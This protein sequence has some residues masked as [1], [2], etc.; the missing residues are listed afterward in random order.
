MKIC[1]VA[2]GNIMVTPYIKKYSEICRNNNLDFDVI[3]WDRLGIKE[4][5]E[6]CSNIYSFNKSMPDDTPVCKKFVSMY[7]YAR[8]IKKI[9]QKNKYDKL[10][11]WTSL[12]GV[13]LESYITKKYKGK[14]IFDIRDYSYENIRWYY[15]KMDS[16]MKNSG[17][18]ILS[19]KG[20]MK[21]LPQNNY[22]VLHNCNYDSIGDYKFDNK[23]DKINIS[24]VGL[25][26]FEDKCKEFLRCIKNNEQIEFHFWGTGEGEAG[27]KEYCTDNH[28]DNVFFHG[29]YMPQEKGNICKNCD[30][31]FN[32]Y[33]NRLGLRYALSNKYYDALYYKKPLLVSENTIMEELSDGVS[34]TVEYNEKFAH[35]LLCKY[36]SINSDQ[37]NEHCESYLQSAID[38]N[39]RT[40]SEICKF[41]M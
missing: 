8:Y 20:F 36:K 13:F 30:M 15:N 37:F 35:E 40:E 17:L 3:Y 27:L 18:N 5:I 9:I 31:M 23:S 33:G 32:A 4:D 39:I 2:F 12:L 7:R 14:Y 19:S 25:V 28:Y 21:F 11:I 26:R 38:E 1:I 34:F 41:L 24:F 6:G 16:L 10:V 29:K 22:L